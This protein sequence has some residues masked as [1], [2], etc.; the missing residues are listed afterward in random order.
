MINTVC[1]EVVTHP[2]NAANDTSFDD[3]STS[4][5]ETKPPRLATTCRLTLAPVQKVEQKADH[6][7]GSA[8]QQ[9]GEKA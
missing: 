6:N 2:A 8:H 3:A 4:P 7:L 5:S 1:E 9:D